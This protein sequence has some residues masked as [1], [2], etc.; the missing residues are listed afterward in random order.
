M[1]CH[2]PS[3]PLRSIPRPSPKP[4]VIPPKV[5]TLPSH[6]TR[7]A[8]SVATEV[9]LVLLAASSRLAIRYTGLIEV[10]GII[11]LV[12]AGAEM[13]AWWGLDV[14]VVG[15]TFVV[16]VDVSAHGVEICRGT[17][18][19]VSSCG[20]GGM[21]LVWIRSVGVLQR[22][23]FS[24]S[25]QNCYSPISSPLLYTPFSVAIVQHTHVKSHANQLSTAGN[26]GSEFG[27]KPY[28]YRMNNA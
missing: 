13:L 11:D 6:R 9:E 14:F 21:S 5:P 23:L 27:A 25:R 19:D 16:A 2:Y 28:L 15:T 10:A 17:E 1:E 7:R 4:T 26:S 12:Q 3:K 8:I 20:L 18:R 22:T 24:V